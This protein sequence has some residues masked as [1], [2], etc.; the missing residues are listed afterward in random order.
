MS[1][2]SAEVPLASGKSEI[3]EAVLR[4]MP[5]WVQIT[6]LSLIVLA[7][8]ISWILKLKR[9]IEHR[10]AVRAGAPV[11]AAAQYGQG[12]GADYLGAYAPQQSQQAQPQQAA[13]AAQPSG[14][15]FLGAYA[16]QQSQQ[17]QPQQAAAAAQPSGAD[18]LG[19]YA[20]QQRR[21]DT[22]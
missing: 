21:D 13:S 6:V 3:F 19:A 5:E 8:V 9:K 22:Q 14:A 10:R 15:D 4:F 11:H 18:F 16:P 7:V 2:A 12:R 20:P 17:A 1:N